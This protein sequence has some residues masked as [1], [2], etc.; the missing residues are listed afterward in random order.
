MA[1]NVRYVPLEVF[2]NVANKRESTVYR[3]RNDIPGLTYQ[4]GRYAILEGTRYPCDLHRYQI[5]DSAD[6]RYVLLKTISKNEYICANDL[7]LYER[8][9]RELLND[10][11]MA[12]LIRE[13]GVSNQYGANGYDCTPEGDE[14]LES[15]KGQA[16]KRI[17]ELIGSF[18]GAAVESYSTGMV[19]V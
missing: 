12:G 5:S 18:V 17:A 4:D 3:R 13:N 15:K 14:L 8:Q 1:S 16:K 2:L 6:K 9:F 19:G 11:L 7:G 10:L